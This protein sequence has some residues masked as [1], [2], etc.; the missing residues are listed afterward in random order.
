MGDFF[1]WASS[2]SFP[3]LPLPSPLS[4]FIFILL[5]CVDG[6]QGGKQCSLSLYC[7]QKQ[8]A[9]LLKLYGTIC[10]MFFN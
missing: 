2:P 10:F 5:L 1:E 3:L 9:Y 7:G 6:E 8:G 4:L